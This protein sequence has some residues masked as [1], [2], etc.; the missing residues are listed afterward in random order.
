[1]TSGALPG[2]VDPDLPDAARD[3]LADDGPLA[4]A[5]PGFRPRAGQQALA[6]S[7]GRAIVERGTLV[8]EAG[9]GTGKT[10]AYLVPLLLAGGKAMVSTGTRPLQ[11]QLHAR[12]LPAVRAA[13]GAGLQTA[14]LKGR[15]N[16][17]CHHHLQR[18]L[19]DGRF[20]D[21]ATPMKLRRIARFAA[22]SATGDRAECTELPEDDAAWGWATSTRENCLG[23]DCPELARCCVVRARREAMNADLVVVNHHLFCADLALREDSLG[24]LL[25]T[26]DAVVFDEAHQLPEAATEFFGEAVSTRQL[27]ELA[28]DLVRAGVVQAPDGADWRSLADRLEHSSRELRLAFEA[29]DSRGHALRGGA[30]GAVS[31]RWTAE[32]LRALPELDDVLDAVLAD[33]VSVSAIVANNAGRGPDLD[34]CGLR[35]TDIGERLQRWSAALAADARGHRAGPGA[36]RADPQAD[37]DGVSDDPDFVRRPAPGAEDPAVVW[38]ET[39]AQHATL[40]RTPLSV[41]ASFDKHR[42]GTPRAWIFLSATLSVGGDFGH[43]VDALGLHDARCERWESPFDFASQAALWIPRGLGETSAPGFAQRVAQAAWPLVKAN[44]GRA[45]FLCTTLRAMREIA[46]RLAELDAAD[47]IGLTR[48]VQGEAPRPLLL[49]RFRSEPNAVL[50]GSASFWEGVDVAGDALSLVVID[51]LPFAPPDDPVVKARGEA[52]RRAGRDPFS[53]ESLPAAAMALKQGAGRL[54]RSERDRGVLM[55]CDERLVTR[56]YGRRLI[57]SLPPFARVERW[58]DALRFLPG[59]AVD[60]VAGR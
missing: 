25:P 46:E 30:R 8:A 6:Q 59:V 42:A 45:F 40:R 58:Q 24:E 1:M 21:P 11:D 18:H 4:R 29:S 32:Q 35:A 56:G 7:I 17:V 16:Y 12:D 13:L 49:E 54:I 43:F 55:V 19:T 23:Q 51:K 38:A 37:G 5:I 27:F 15:S 48:L 36:D 20:P 2:A 34:R 50:V 57:A 14:L 28:R 53:H 52:L 31:R 33:L 9:T 10:Y 39:G 26:A 47:G 22:T 60:D 44:R 3:A 41:A